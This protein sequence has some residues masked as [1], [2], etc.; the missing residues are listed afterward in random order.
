MIEG[1]LIEP[2]K[3]ISDEKGSVMHMLRSDAPLF[4]QFGEV[5][6]SVANPGFVKGWKKHLKITQH[7]TVPIGNIKLVIY[8]DRKDSSTVNK[9]Q[10][11]FVGIENYQL[12]RIPPLVWYSFKAVGGEPALISNCTDLP[13]DPSEVISTDLFDNKIPYTWEFKHG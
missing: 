8:D 1:I 2:L 11:I 7:F 13:Y 5:Y 10:E 6:F 4:K 9:V 12:V 3:I